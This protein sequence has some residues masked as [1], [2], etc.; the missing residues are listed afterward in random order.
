MRS[1]SPSFLSGAD[2]IL[3]CYTEIVHTFWKEFSVVNNNPE[4]NAKI[5]RK[6]NGE[7]DRKDS[8]PAVLTVSS[9]RVTPPQSGFSKRDWMESNGF[10][11]EMM[12]YINPTDFAPSLFTDK[13][14]CSR[15]DCPDTTAS[16]GWTITD[17]NGDD[18]QVCAKC[19]R[20][21]TTPA[22][23][24]RQPRKADPS[25]GEI[26]IDKLSELIEAGDLDDDQVEEI[27]EW[28]EITTDETIYDTP[29]YDGSYTG[30]GEYNEWEQSDEVPYYDADSGTIQNIT[31]SRPQKWV[32]GYELPYYE[33]T[34]EKESSYDEP[35]QLPPNILKSLRQAA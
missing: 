28:N 26:S 22:D 24:P 27:M 23:K 15:R 11:E 17:L 33:W 31:W 10:D 19:I 34:V 14:G 2:I 16:P 3:N 30:D 29:F 32:Y 5:K 12:L 9:N 18:H 25:Q 35:L 7:F 20:K 13:E 1:R 8:S 4:F 21:M 6:P